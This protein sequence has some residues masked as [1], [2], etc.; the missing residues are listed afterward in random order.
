MNTLALDIPNISKLNIIA[1]AGT[2]RHE[3]IALLHNTAIV[4]SNVEVIQYFKVCKICFSF[5]RLLKYIFQ[6][7]YWVSLFLYKMNS[8]TYWQQNFTL[9]Q[10]NMDNTYIHGCIIA[11]SLKF[12]I[13]AFKSIFL[14]IKHIFLQ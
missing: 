1:T 7:Y 13:K 6:F 12:Y 3:N 5:L 9:I 2:F 10:T 4:M 11:E 8:G 14:N